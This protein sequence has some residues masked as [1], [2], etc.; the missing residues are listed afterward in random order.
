MKSKALNIL[1]FIAVIAAFGTAKASTYL[2]DKREC[3]KGEAIVGLA[4]GTVKEVLKIDQQ[5][6]NEEKGTLVN[7]KKD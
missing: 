2:C 7:V 6:L 3:T 5:V 4:K 1:I